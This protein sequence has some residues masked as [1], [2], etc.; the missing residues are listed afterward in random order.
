VLKGTLGYIVGAPPMGAT[1]YE[2]AGVLQASCSKANCRTEDVLDMATGL[3]SFLEP[4]SAQPNRPKELLA[5]IN[6]L[7][8]HEK[9]KP[10]MDSM[11]TGM[12]VDG[13]TGEDGVIALGNLLINNTKAIGTTKAAF[14]HDYHCNIEVQLNST[15]G[16][17]VNWSDPAYASLRTMLDQFIGAHTDCNAPHNGAHSLLYD[18]LDP[19][20]P[21]PLLVPMQKV[22]ACSQ[23]NDPNSALMKMVYQLAFVEDTL[24]LKNL[25]G[26]IEQV[27]NQDDRLAILTFT[28]TLLKM[29]RADEEGTA[30]AR[31]LCAQALD[32]HPP[33]DGGRTNAQLVL[34]VAYDLFAAGA[35]SE[36]IC[37]AD[38]L[39][40]GCAG[41]SQPAC[42]P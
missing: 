39:L 28:K 20:R 15:L 11:S 3:L 8:N 30:A 42:A 36:L 9:L 33:A 4:T 18:M 2:V 21:E 41:G 31:K 29:I 16:S 26:A 13:K 32:T 23:E 14:E 10:L 35:T 7:L 27:A 25:M 6:A 17:L 34:P 19:T 1:H 38:T 22:L 37:V 24:G 12:T 5:Q 40:F